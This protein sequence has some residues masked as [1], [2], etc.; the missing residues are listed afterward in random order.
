MTMWM[1]EEKNMKKGEKME[2]EMRNIGKK[3]RHKYIHTRIRRMVKA[4]DWKSTLAYFKYVEIV[5][6]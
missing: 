2:E 5:R 3:H 6:N 1:A 4:F